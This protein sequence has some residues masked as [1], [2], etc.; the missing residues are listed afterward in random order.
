MISDWTNVASYSYLANSPLVGQITFKS[1]SF[2]AMTTTKQY[3][4]LNRL[5]SISSTPSNAI[6]YQYNVVNQR[7]MNQLWDGSYWRYGY[8]PLGQV[9]F[10]SKF[11]VDETP[12][13]GQQFDYA[14]DTIGNRTQ[15]EAGGD[16][17]GANLRVAAYTNNTLNQIT[18]RGVPA[19][20]DV[21]GDGLATNGVTVNGLTAYRKNEYFR[22][23]LSVT[24]TSPVWDSVT[25]AATGQTSVTGHIYV[26]QAPENYTYDADGNMLSDGRW[27]NTW[28]AE[29]RLL[30]MTSLST[31]PSGSQLQLAFTYDYMGRRI[32]KLVSTNNGTTYVGEYTNKYA[33][34]AWNC[35]AIL[36]PSLV[37]S[38]SFLWGSDLSGSLQGA[39][40]VGGLIKVSYYGPATTN[41]FVAYDGNG[42]VSALIN[43]SNGV[44][45]AN[46]DYG[47]FGEVIRMSGPMAKLNPFRFSTKY[48]DDE[49]DFLYYGYRYYNAST[50]RWPSKDP[51][52]E[53]GGLNLYSFVDN[54][55][56]NNSD[57]LGEILF[58]FVVITNNGGAHGRGNMSGQWGSPG[59]F[60]TGSSSIQL[61]SASTTV[62]GKGP[63]RGHCCNTV[64]S[65]KE[66]SNGNAGSIIAYMEDAP[67]G[68]Y[69]VTLIASGNASV[70]SIPAHQPAASVGAT[71]TFYDEPNNK[72]QLTGTVAYPSGPFTWAN[73]KTFTVTVVIPKN[74]ARVQIALYNLSM[75][76][77]QCGNV[78]VT[79]TGTLTVRTFK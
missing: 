27:T 13:A 42:N 68:T 79:A 43:A 26:A 23:Q 29:N 25:V 38:N 19:A 2:T 47:A 22:Q 59:S 58:E 66:A 28:D 35:L 8:D 70:T 37:L 57:V 12:V 51:I 63:V 6:T 10:G 45:V 15:T 1:N 3:D 53:Q 9:I 31:A 16:Q 55:S 56:I 72:V 48:D 7:T 50:G 39:G 36:N 34:D 52:G 76:L 61:T 17:N 32:Q 49:T 41:C 14:F 71:E 73:S 33:Y 21:M 11:W 60:F 18:S 77:N 75:Q 67:K 40:G 62:T 78:S 30:S 69:T 65:D 64:I 20:V 24:N 44:T 74:N 46:Y 4:L 5:A 54:N